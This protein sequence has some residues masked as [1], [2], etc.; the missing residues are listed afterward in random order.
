MNFAA[1]ASGKIKM[2]LQSFAIGT[3]L[4]KM[5]HVPTATWGYYF[6]TIIFIAMVVATI[7]SGVLAT[8][9]PSLRQPQA[10]KVAR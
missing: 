5:A 3:V 6:T 2:L 9:R 1:T 8:R 7:V 4:V 10:E